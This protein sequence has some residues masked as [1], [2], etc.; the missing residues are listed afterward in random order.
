MK[1]VTIKEEF[2]IP[3]T[4]IILEE[5]DQIE[6]LKEDDLTSMMRDRRSGNSISN[7]LSN[8]PNYF[9]EWAYHTLSNFTDFDAEEWGY[10]SVHQVIE[11]GMEDLMDELEATKNYIQRSYEKIRSKYR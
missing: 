1:T 2:R 3:G 5:G 6:V 7:M 11:A 4:D 9:E 10:D 8:F